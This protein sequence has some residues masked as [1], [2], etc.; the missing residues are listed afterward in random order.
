MQSELQQTISELRK[1]RDEVQSLRSQLAA[2]VEESANLK[3][4][5][6]SLSETAANMERKLTAE[7]RVHHVLRFSEPTGPVTLFWLA[8]I[9]AVFGM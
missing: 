1:S 5:L 6:A 2:A 8:R 9:H 3:S 7:V 4:E